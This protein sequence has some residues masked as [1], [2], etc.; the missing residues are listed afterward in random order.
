MN[1]KVSIVRLL[2]GIHAVLVSCSHKGAEQLPLN[3]RIIAKYRVLDEGMSPGFAKCS[4]ERKEFLKAGLYDC[5]FKLYN[6]EFVIEKKY[7][8]DSTSKL[9][10]YWP[11]HAEGPEVITREELEKDT[12]LMRCE[13]L[14]NFHVSFA[15]RKA[16]VDGYDTVTITRIFPK[17]K[18]VFTVRNAKDSVNG[19]RMIYQYQ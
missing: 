2:L 17:E 8:V 16:I 5:S 13:G 1:N 19:R 9:K 7:L 11:Y 3:S 6:L 12:S 18:L 4:E 14:N 15:N 10:E